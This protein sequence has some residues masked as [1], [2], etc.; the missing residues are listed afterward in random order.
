M[1]AGLGRNPQERAATIARRRLQVKLSGGIRNRK[2]PA[3]LLLL[4]KLLGAAS[5]FVGLTAEDITH[6]HLKSFAGM[7]SFLRLRRLLLLLF[8]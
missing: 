3:L 1:K 7:L 6:I 8:Q 4:V 2:S 5:L